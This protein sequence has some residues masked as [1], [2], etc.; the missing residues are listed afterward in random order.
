MAQAE[1]KGHISDPYYFWFS[2]FTPPPP[3]QGYFIDI[4]IKSK[5][6]MQM[7]FYQGRDELWRATRHCNS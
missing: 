5:F 3:P 1:T 2:F 7:R 4:F 6:N